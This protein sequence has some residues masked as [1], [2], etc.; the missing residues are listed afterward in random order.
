M[1]IPNA[2]GLERQLGFSSDDVVDRTECSL[3]PEPGARSQV[4]SML[5]H[6]PTGRRA[7]S[8]GI[9]GLE[10]ERDRGS[11]HVHTFHGPLWGDGHECVLTRTDEEWRVTGCIMLYIS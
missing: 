11:F 3:E 4:D 9:S 1:C 2:A 5:V 10:L 8:V 6:L 7:L